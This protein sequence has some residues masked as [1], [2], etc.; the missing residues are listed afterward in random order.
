MMEIPPGYIRHG[1][2]DRRLPPS[3]GQALL[4]LTAHENVARTSLTLLMHNFNLKT[5]CR[6]D[7]ITQNKALAEVIHPFD[8]IQIKTKPDR[9]G[10]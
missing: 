7:F 8:Y 1:V 2:W 3:V 9:M 6:Q 4:R 10:M 5:G